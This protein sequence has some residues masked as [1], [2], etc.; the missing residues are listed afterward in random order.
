M[1]RRQ[2]DKGKRR[3]RGVI[4]A[5]IV[6]LVLATGVFVVLRAH[7]QAARTFVVYVQGR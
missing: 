2:R 5:A 6:A 3:H 1:D 7:E 4:V